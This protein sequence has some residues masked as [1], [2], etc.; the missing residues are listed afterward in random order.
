MTK[1]NTL[2]L[3]K[4]VNKISMN[5]LRNLVSLVVLVGLNSLVI[6]QNHGIGTVTPDPSAILELK[7]QDKGLLTP[8]LNTSER[9]LI[10]SPKEG[11]IIFNTDE[12]CIE[13]FSNNQWNL[14]CACNSYAGSSTV[15]ST[16][17][18]Y[19]NG[20]SITLS[21]DTINGEIQWQFALEDLKFYNIDNAT[22]AT[23]KI[24]SK[25]CEVYYRAKVQDGTCDPVYSDTQQV[26]YLSK[27]QWTST[28]A[29]PI[30]TFR[31]NGFTVNGKGYVIQGDNNFTI[32]EYDPLLDIWTKKTDPPAGMRYEQSMVIDNVAYIFTN[33]NQLWIYEPVSETWTQKKDRPVFELWYRVFTINNVGYILSVSFTD[34]DFYSYYPASDYWLLLP[35]IPSTLPAHLF[36]NGGGVQYGNKAYVFFGS[37]N[38]GQAMLWEYNQETLSWTEKSKPPFTGGLFTFPIAWNLCDKLYFGGHGTTYDRQELL[39]YRPETDTWITRI[40][41]PFIKTNGRQMFNFQMDNK[42][43]VGLGRDCVSQ[44]GWCAGY[45]YTDETFKYCP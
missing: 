28:A 39:E 10:V 32:Y 15:S 35:G 45:M 16:T 17:V 33:T 24:R 40:K 30:D 1:R 26:S 19:C 2:Y 22:T 14:A 21:I 23:E 8:R 18:D 42:G 25:G 34:M 13:V 4:S 38:P 11:L 3:I 7:T 31:A 36:G 12:N 37:G 9:D 41:A 20:D 29:F 43:Y 5:S 6:A 27:N 44:S